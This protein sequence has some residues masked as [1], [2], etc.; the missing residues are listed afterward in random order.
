MTSK[1]DQ[2]RK[3]HVPGDP[4]IL[5][6]VWDAGSASAAVKAGAKA[7]ATG[8][9]SVAAANGFGDGE[10]VPMA[11]AL[12]NA[13]RIVGTA[14]VPVTVDFEGGYAADPDGV[15]KNIALLAATGA[16]GCNFED[17]IVGGDG[18][19]PV[20][21]QCERL[22]A[23]R[24]GAGNAFFINARTDIFLKARPDAH[25]AAAT[26]AAIE[27]AIAYAEAGASGYFIPGL[28][29][30]DLVERIT[31][32]SPIPVNAMWLPNGPTNA[33]WAAAG[34]ARISHGPFPQMALMKTFEQMARE[35]LA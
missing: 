11:F 32:A 8:S 5:F 30:L 16:I 26:D 27:R 33:Q 4:L 22:K 6:N 31:K 21:E 24:R 17:Q 13:E 3:S 18:I 19:W 14:D 15:A 35:A 20:Q 12:T 23:A 9:A 1:Y 7:I 29:N 28:A 2:F 34:I 25:D 10:E